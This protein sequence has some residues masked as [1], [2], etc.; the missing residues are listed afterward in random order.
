MHIVQL[1]TVLYVYASLQWSRKSN[2]NLIFHF[3]V[4]SRSR[5]R[6]PSFSLPLN[7]T[8]NHISAVATNCTPEKTKRN[9]KKT[10]Q[11]R[12]NLIVFIPFSGKKFSR[13]KFSFLCCVSHRFRF[14][15]AR[16]VY[17]ILDSLLLLPIIFW[18]SVH[19]QVVNCF[20]FFRCFI[21]VYLR[22]TKCTVH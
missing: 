1:C 4:I 13:L 16:C 10:L 11:Y 8:V 18:L 21:C 3:Q 15:N 12:Q 9:V 17:R 2:A 5:A 22:I 6:T 20:F 7:Y 19:F 14:R